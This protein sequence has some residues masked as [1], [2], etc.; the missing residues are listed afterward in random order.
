MS[1]TQFARKKG[2]G[3]RTGI[4]VDVVVEIEDALECGGGRFSHASSVIGDTPLLRCGFAVVDPLDRAPA[5]TVDGEGEDVGP[6]VVPR[7]VEVVL[8]GNRLLDV[9]V[10]VNDAWCIDEWFDDPCAVRAGGC[11]PAA[12]K[13]AGLGV[14]GPTPA[15]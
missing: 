9:D 15:R 14:S 8:V 1:I 7:Y 2:L 6:R 3:S 4:S 13:T 5:A 12:N 10:G 11:R